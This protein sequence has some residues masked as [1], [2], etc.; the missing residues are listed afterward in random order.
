MRRGPEDDDDRLRRLGEDPDISEL[1][2]RMRAE[3][4]AEAAEY[5]V[6]AA[7]DL[8]RSRGLAEVLLAAATR[9][10]EV[11]VTLANARVRGVVED[12]VGDL[13]RLRTADEAVDVRID[14][15][16]LLRVLGAAGRPSGE[17]PRRTAA[18]FRARLAEHEAAAGEVLLET[19]GPGGGL[20]GVVA[21]VAIDHLV[22]ELH[23]GGRV[24]VAFGDA[25]A[26][27]RR[28]GRSR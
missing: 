15:I 11:E 13:A 21:V 14:A 20:R 25:E 1:G 28:R 3:L 10:E 8:A 5:E 12:A 23:G 22:L 9:D 27:R 24:H 19:G 16:R 18:S 4:R 26:V 2:V 6:L 7:L 17:R